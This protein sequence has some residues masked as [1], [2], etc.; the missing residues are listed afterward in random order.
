M[1][2]NK[3]LLPFSPPED[4]CVRLLSLLTEDFSEDVPITT[5]TPTTY[6]SFCCKCNEKCAAN[7]EN[8]R[9]SINCNCFM[10]FPCHK[11]LSKTISMLVVPKNLIKLEGINGRAHLIGNR[12]KTFGVVSKDHAQYCLISCSKTL[13]TKRIDL[14]RN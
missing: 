6:D 10:S 13:F 8:N 11:T 7:Y 1:Q 3:G 9:I 12:Y 2:T 14:F 4:S 5:I